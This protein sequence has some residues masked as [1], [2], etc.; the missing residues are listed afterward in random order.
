MEPERVVR[1]LW[2]R[3]EARDWSGAGA[4]LAPDIRVEWPA[5]GE[6][7]VGR[8]NFLAVQSEYPEGWTINVIRTV[9]EGA[10]VVSEV[11][12]PH[13]EFGIFRAASFWTVHDDL[14]TEAT[15]YWVNVGGEQP[16][17]WRSQYAQPRRAGVTSNQDCSPRSPS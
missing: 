6:V 15:E 14:V 1:G 8:D 11:E 10:V 13:A 12:V 2:D 4:L 5:T 3:I 9:A 7:F 16:P 17:E